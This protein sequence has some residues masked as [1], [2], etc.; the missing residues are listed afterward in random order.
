MKNTERQ[1]FVDKLNEILNNKTSK[2]SAK[3]REKIIVIREKIIVS[4]NKLS[5][6][7]AIADLVKLVGLFEILDQ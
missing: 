4:K 2:L 7:K 1:F 6:V 3:D 5:I